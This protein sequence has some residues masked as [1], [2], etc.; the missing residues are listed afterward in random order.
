MMTNSFIKTQPHCKWKI[1]TSINHL[2]GVKDSIEQIG[3][4]GLA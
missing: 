1:V 3:V 2:P 4:G